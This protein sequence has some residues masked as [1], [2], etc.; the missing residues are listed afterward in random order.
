MANGADTADKI[1]SEIRSIHE[2]LAFI[3]EHMVDADSILSEEDYKAILDSRLEKKRG[4]L[5]SLGDLK[6]EIGL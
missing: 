3:K 6:K 1:F 2:D 4:K 5:I